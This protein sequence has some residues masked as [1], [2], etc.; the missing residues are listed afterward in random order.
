MSVHERQLEGFHTDTIKCVYLTKL[1]G[2]PWFTCFALDGVKLQLRKSP[3]GVINTQ[4]R[5]CSTDEDLC[6]L[7]SF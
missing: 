2:M 4:L 6:L 7:F 3:A 5:E 1:T